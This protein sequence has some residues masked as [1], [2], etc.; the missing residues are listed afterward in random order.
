MKSLLVSALIALASCQPVL[1]QSK[2]PANLAQQPE[3]FCLLIGVASVGIMDRLNAGRP[4]EYVYDEVSRVDHPELRTRLNE[5]V[6][7]ASQFRAAANVGAKTK[8]KDGSKSAANEQASSQEFSKWN[9][10]RC[11]RTMKQAPA[12]IYE[13]VD[14]QLKKTS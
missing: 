13:M 2:Y 9:Y 11:M 7:L 8:E 4:I 5:T 10:Q 3:K 12:E 14:G 1:A 6:T